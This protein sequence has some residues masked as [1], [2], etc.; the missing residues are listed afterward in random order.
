MQ[1]Q[2][3]KNI[4]D[5]SRGD[6]LERLSVEDKAV[7]HEKGMLHLSSHLLIYT[8]EGQIYC[9]KRKE[10]E[11]RYAGLWTTTIGIHVELGKDYFQTLSSYLPPAIMKLEFI[12]EFRTQ[13]MWENEIN[14]L[15]LCMINNPSFPHGFSEDIRLI[16]AAQL[17]LLL[18]QGKTTPHLAKAYNLWREKHGKR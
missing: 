9:R 3:Y 8:S 2:T 14:G 13:D 12:G 15:Y 16:E 7:A 5:W 1:I 11:E 4:P 10:H 17:E 18:F 6:N